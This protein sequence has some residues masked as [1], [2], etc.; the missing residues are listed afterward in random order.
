[1]HSSL[2]HSNTEMS[3]KEEDPTE[4]EQSMMVKESQERIVSGKASEEHDSRWKE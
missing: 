1:M 4:K 3:G 2:R